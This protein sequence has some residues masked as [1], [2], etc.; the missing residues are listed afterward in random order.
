VEQA[1]VVLEEVMRAAMQAA[2]RAATQAADG[3]RHAAGQVF[4]YH[5]VLDVFKEQAELLGMKISDAELAAF[6]P[7]QLIQL[8][9]PRKAA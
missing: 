8:S 7:D 6:D 1:Q 3:D 4:A 9:A 2:L 5:D